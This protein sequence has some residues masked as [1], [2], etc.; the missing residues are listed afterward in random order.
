MSESHRQCRMDV[1]SDTDVG[2]GS[3]VLSGRGEVGSFSA[4]R[5][6]SRRIL[7]LGGS[8]SRV[9]ALRLSDLLSR[10]TWRLLNGSMGCRG[11][12]GTTRAKRS[13]CV[14]ADRDGV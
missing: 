11:S 7:V 4:I 9:V 3:C 6:A 8:C 12:G 13:G 10:N 14:A 2:P 1:I 5:M